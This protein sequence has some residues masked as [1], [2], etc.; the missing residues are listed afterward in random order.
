MTA[1]A[2][3]TYDR[4][5]PLAQRL[6]LETRDHHDRI[7]LAFDLD[8]RLASRAAYR[9]L[10]VRLHGFHSGFEAAAR[11]RLS[12]TDFARYLDRGALIARD[13][14]ALDAASGALGVNAEAHEG[15]PLELPDRASALGALYVV[16]GSILGGVLIAKEVGRRLGLSAEGGAAFFAGHGRETART[17]AEFCR[18][19]DAEAGSEIGDEAIASAGRTYRVMQAWLCDEVAVP[20]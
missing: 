18:M 9:D 10:L 12:G 11:P 8:G 19:L 3:L 6:R 1:G 17:W 16:E 15:P 5:M 20:A 13:I 14:A 4:V 2:D 7:E